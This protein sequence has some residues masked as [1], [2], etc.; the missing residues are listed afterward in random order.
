MCFGSLSQFFSQSSP[1]RRNRSSDLSPSLMTLA[2]S[3]I[4][5]S[6]CRFTPSGTDNSSGKLSVVARTS[7]KVA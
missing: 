3:V 7:A 4:E 6:S 5:V 2:R 1:R